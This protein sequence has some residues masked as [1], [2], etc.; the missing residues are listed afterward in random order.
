MRTRLLS[1][2]DHCRTN[3]WFLPTVLIL[4]AVALG[5][6][7]PVL[8]RAD[9]GR[10]GQLGRPAATPDAARTALATIAGAMITVAGVVFSV[11]MVTLSIAA[12]QFGSRV[13]RSRM[14]DKA[15]QLALGAFLGT[16]VYCFVVLRT[17]HEADG[18][19]FVPH[20]SVALAIALAAGSVFVLIYF[21]HNVA[22]VVQA[23]HIVAA[24][25]AELDDSIERLF[26]DKLDRDDDDRE[27][28]GNTGP[29]DPTDSTGHRIESSREGYLQAIDSDTLL[30]LASR[31]DLLIQVDKRLGEFLTAGDLVATVWG[32]SDEAVGIAEE[33][34]EALIVGNLR[35]PRQDLNCTVLELAQLSVRALSPGIND[36]FTAI[37]GI[38]RLAAA[39][40]RLAQRKTPSKYRAD[41]KGQLR[42]IVD[43]AT[44]PDA[45]AAAFNQIRQNAR[46]S[47]P[48]GMRLL[49]ALQS[50]ARKTRRASDRKAILQQAQMVAETF[51]QAGPHPG[52]LRGIREQFERI[53]S[54]LRQQ[55][56]I[57]A[58]D[59]S[60]AAGPPTERSSNPNRKE[61]PSQPE[62]K[63]EVNG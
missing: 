40:G 51:E 25:A 37:N 30:E 46:S 23:P 6:L 58:E 20:L 43:R 12:S 59:T 28:F 52:D 42:L 39:L 4:S 31:D 57:E 22:E 33:I 29:S 44:F 14:Q 24:L 47:P 2:W 17:V 56:P 21:I 55:E 38:D 32:D 45:L 34:N 41:D 15:T 19:A 7:F 49:E 62:A 50:I 16:S 53:E 11:T 27:E 13:L 36:P 18:A 10:W 48:V 9:G 3:F 54:H 5:I 8:D 26:P 60:G 35:T 61:Q 1:V 63:G